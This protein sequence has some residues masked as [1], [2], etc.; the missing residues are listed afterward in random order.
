MP[1]EKGGHIFLKGAC[2]VCGPEL[3]LVM[4]GGG[5]EVVNVV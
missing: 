1:E 4:L 2:T 3:W 5:I